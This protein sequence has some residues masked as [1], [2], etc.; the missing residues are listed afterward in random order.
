MTTN[1]TGDLAGVPSER[2][3]HE[4]AQH[5]AAI[6]SATCRWL[7]MIAELDRR[8]AWAT[9]ECRSMVHWLGWKCGIDRRTGRDHVRVGR[10]L[11]ALPHVTEAFAAGAITYS[12]VRALTRV[13]TPATEADLLDIARNAS[14]SQLDRI[15][16]AYARVREASTGATVERALQV[17]HHADGTVT[18][19]A[20]RCPADTAAAVLA[21]VDAAM[22]DVPAD[23]GDTYAARQVDALH[24]VALA[25]VAPDA[26]TGRRVD[27]NLDIRSTDFA[28]AAPGPT[29]GADTTTA[30][31]TTDVTP[32]ETPNETAH[33]TPSDTPN[34]VHAGGPAAPRAPSPPR[35][36]EALLDGLPIDVELAQEL[37]CDASVFVAVTDADGTVRFV[38]RAKAIPTA[39]RRKAETRDER[40]CRWPGCTNRR[41]L[42][43]HHITWRSRH[44]D[45]ATQN[46]VLLC[47]FHHRAV[48]RRG[49]KIVGDA[50]GALTFAGPDGRV[51][52]ER[53][54]QLP[55]PSPGIVDTDAADG[56]A[57][58][59]LLYEAMD[60]HYVISVL[61]D[62][63]FPLN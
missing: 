57:L 32:N 11:A 24:L 59:P 35:T 54:P 1:V 62:R 30:D 51:L 36:I 42:D 19:T 55:C 4:V 12:K 16:A 29:T 9:W 58:E 45:H 61:A 25:F 6:A 18:I 46:L 22:S 8:E 47:P 10:A 52:P 37:L 26:H 28:G 5:T 53:A 23:L 14:A 2:L 31:T 43:V 17:R 38:K 48:H 7:L 34:E 13:A 20:R 63:H 40:H 21:A 15:F 27:A 49:W 39:A 33:E 44:G 50:N 3:E 41:W 56:R 60:L